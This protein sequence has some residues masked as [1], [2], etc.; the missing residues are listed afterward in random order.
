MK[1][2]HWLL[3]EGSALAYVLLLGTTALAAA[4]E[5]GVAP[6]RGAAPTADTAPSAAAASTPAKMLQV[7]EVVEVAGDRA[8]LSPGVERELVAA[9][10]VTLGKHR[11]RVLASN[12]NNLVIARA[13]RRLTRGQRGTLEVHA[14]R[15]TTFAARP[16]PPALSTFADKWREP[17]RPA[18]AQ[19]PK[20]V[21]LGA[22]RD[23]PSQRVAFMLDHSR[24]QPLSGPAL[25]ID[26]VRLR[27]LLHAELGSSRVALDA[28][29]F[30]E[31]WRADDLASRRGSA[32]RP[33][34]NVRQLELSYRGD[35]FQAGVGR[36][37]YASSTLGMLDGARASASLG[38]TLS[39]GAFGG[40]LAD[41][42]DGRPETDVARF[43]AE[44][45]WQGLAGSAPTRASVT[46]QGSRFLGTTDERRLTAL[47]ESYPGFGHLGA[48]AEVN[49]FDADNPWNAP[50]AELTSIGFD[51]SVRLSK[52]RLGLSLNARLPERSYWL[53]AALPEGFFCV[54]E[55][56]PG[57]DS[58]EPCVGSAR[59][60]AASFTAAW[61]GELWTLDGGV[62]SVTTSLTEAEQN[63][64]FLGYRQRGLWQAGR[65]DVGASASS[66]S[67]LESA[68][69]NVGLGVSLLD[70][71]ADLSVHYRPN[72]LRYRADMVE[73]LEHGVGTRVWWAASSELDLSLSADVLT[74]RDVDVLFLQ[75]A[76]AWR[77]RF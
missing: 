11:Y 59:R 52:V 57:A 64:A 46:A 31:H 17:A 22:A 13:G 7:V 1:S 33:L 49:F 63:T 36:L 44:L 9:P 61:E 43:G 70:D 55:S 45:L 2:R 53:A 27:A 38:E 15:N 34:L 50:S 69:L 42:L 71:S 58:N 12:T 18:E 76:L 73:L 16:A 4:P 47:F 35:S 54:A 41:P 62:T 32:S 3:C 74:S 51:G 65:F 66:G 8:Y 24:T 67:L 25:A 37:R 14:R 75:T 6:T 40:T 39:L 77:P 29:A 72:V 26:R 20:F 68:A 21:P 10:Q 23:K 19:S 30:L 56:T 28:D 48:H 5:R 60:V